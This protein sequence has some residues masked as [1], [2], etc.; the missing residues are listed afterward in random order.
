MIGHREMVHGYPVATDEVPISIYEILGDEIMHLL[1]GYE[2]N[3]RGFTAWK[4][5]CLQQQ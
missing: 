1:Y 5:L 4:V 3:E 2:L